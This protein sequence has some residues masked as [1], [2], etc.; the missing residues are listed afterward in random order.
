MQSLGEFQD[1][2]SMFGIT[3]FFYAELIKYQWVSLFFQVQTDKVGWSHSKDSLV[4]AL[5]L[6]VLQYSFI[7]CLRVSAL[8]LQFHSVQLLLKFNVLLQSQ[9]FWRFWL[10]LAQCLYVTG[11]KDSTTMSTKNSML[12]MHTF[13]N[14]RET[15][16]LKVKRRI[17][18]LL[19]FK[20]QTRLNNL[21]F[22]DNLWLRRL[23]LAAKHQHQLE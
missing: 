6:F 7:W 22:L 5:N 11:L 21:S 17:M 23:R 4:F 10:F 8:I 15:R 3:I 9:Y 13:L 18:A 12:I 2:L 16:M 14:L 20:W 1:C 19:A